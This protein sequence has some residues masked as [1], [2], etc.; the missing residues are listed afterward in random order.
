VRHTPSGGTVTV[1]VRRDADEVVV[2]VADTGSGV[3]AEHL[4]HVFDR[5]YRAGAVSGSG[6]G[7][8][9][10][11]QLVEAQ[12]GR[13]EIASTAGTGTTVTIRLPAN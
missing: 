5:S 3:T 12:H 7:L 10:T 6:L 1:S 11:R 13:V 9:I 2:A 8:A 4:P